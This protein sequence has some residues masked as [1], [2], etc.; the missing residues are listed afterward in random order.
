MF[1]N[2]QKEVGT[3]YE[4]VWLAIAKASAAIP[5]V[6]TTWTAVSAGA[7]QAVAA[8]NATQFFEIDASAAQVTFDFPA[9][10]V[11]GQE[12]VLKI[13]SATT[14]ADVLLVAGGATE[15]E[16]P[17]T[18]GTFSAPGGTV[19]LGGQGSVFRV[20]YQAAKTRWVQSA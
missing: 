2:L 6:P 8:Q 7:T 10:P 16:D 3:L 18:P 4:L 1:Q 12:V 17:G 5:V 9:N 15:M 19:G 13:S 20:K 14:A 11:N